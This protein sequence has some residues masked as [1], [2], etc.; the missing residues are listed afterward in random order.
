MRHAKSDYTSTL[1][2]PLGIGLEAYVPFVGSA[3]AEP[4]LGD[5]AIPM[6]QVLPEVIAAKYADIDQLVRPRA[7]LLDE[8]KPL[9]RR[10]CKVLGERREYV[11]Y[12]QRQEVWALW[13]LVDARDAIATATIAAVPKRDSSALRKS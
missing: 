8:L 9:N 5:S 4:P 7:T 3:I 13:E 12:F 2:G 10:F 6:L 1:P 11:A